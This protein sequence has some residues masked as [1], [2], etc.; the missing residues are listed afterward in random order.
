MSRARSWRTYVVAAALLT[1]GAGVA[2]QP[3]PA[4]NFVLPAPIPVSPAAKPAE[5]RRIQVQVVCVRV[6]A[7]FASRAGLTADGKPGVGVACGLTPREAKLF[8]A[9]LRADREVEVL[10]RP[11]LV[12]AE[13]QTG[14]FQIDN[15]VEMVAGLEAV[16]KDGATLYA[17]KMVKVGNPCLTLRLTPSFTADGKSILLRSETTCCTVSGTP[18]LIRVSATQPAAD[19]KA[20]DSFL[21]CLGQ[22]VRNEQSM[23]M[24]VLLPDGGSAV[25][26]GLM[27]KDVKQSPTE[28]LWVMTAHVIEGAK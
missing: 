19:A 24:S 7:G 2:Q 27:M 10:A 6:P 15:S 25:A 22:A 9:L 3:A 26:G 13:G 14:F 12:L 1:G 18:A 20:S 21:Q 28:L 8:D 4:P 17:P 16:T 5:S 11:Q 23:Q